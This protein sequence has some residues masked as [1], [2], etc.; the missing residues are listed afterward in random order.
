MCNPPDIDLIKMAQ[1]QQDDVQVQAYRTAISKLVLAD[2]PI[3][4]TNTTLLCDTSTGVPRPIVPQSWRRT[5][6]NTIHGLAHP[7][8]RASRKLVSSRFVWHGV[9]KQ[10]GLWAKTCIPCQ[11]AKVQRHVSA[12]LEHGQLPDRRFQKIHVDIVGPLPVPQGQNYLLTI[13]D[14][15]T[16]W[17]EAI[18]IADATATTCA[19]ALLF[20]HIAQFGVPADISSDRGPQF[21]SHLWT[22]LNCLMGTQLHRTT[23]YHPQS[24]GIVERLHRQLKSALKARLIGPNWM[25][26]LPLVLLGLRSIPKEDLGCAPSELVYGTTLRLPGEFFEESAT[27]TDPS[28]SELLT[29]L[30]TTMAKIRPKQTT[31]H[32]R[33]IAYAPPELQNCKFVFVRHDAHR[34]P[35][36][37]TYDGP[38]RVVNRSVKFFTLDLH[39]KLD[40]VSV[41]RF[42]PAFV[43]P[44]FIPPGESIIPGTVNEPHPPSSSDNANSQGLL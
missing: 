11:R 8:I 19:R 10:V 26:E 2:L 22:A 4:G 9:N 5:V 44:D 7:G 30:R 29:Y 37:C 23:A 17:P 32:R 14:R 15:Y 40:T 25:D 13:I 39:G 35:L 1:A 38:F 43:D 34:T 33:H 36:Q 16:R 41:D 21:T 6:F 42:K 18:P 20:H 27:S 12:S 31:H 24:N 3:P 28:V